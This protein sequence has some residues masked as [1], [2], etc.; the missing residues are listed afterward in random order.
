MIVDHIGLKV[1]DVDASVRFYEAALAPLGLVVCSRD[2]SGAG[3]GP[4]GEPALWLQAGGTGSSSAHVALRARD[5]AAVDRFHASGLAA[6]GRDN[7][8]PGLRADYGPSYY[9]AFLID[10]DGNNIEAVCLK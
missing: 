6:G 5:R 7:G 4:A 1:A 10:P 2:G 8:A 9:A 3:L